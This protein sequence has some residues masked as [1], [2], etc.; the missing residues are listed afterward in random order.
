MES[1]VHWPISAFFFGFLATAFMDS[2]ALIQ[3]RIWPNPSFNYCLL[4]RW[5]LHIKTGNLILLPIYHSKQQPFECYIGW[6]SHY[7]IG[8]V[9]AGLYIVVAT[10]FSL[11]I[12]FI[13]VV[14]FGLLTVAAPFLIMQ[15]GLG[16]G[17][18]ASKTPNPWL[19]RLRSCIAHLSYGIG[20]F[21]S[22]QAFG[23][24]MK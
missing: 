6:F 8:I 1:E 16:L 14:G 24:V 4:G 18:F 2:W 17:F 12:S 21:L 20:L 22:F 10:F 9:F 19:V 23:K 13:T 11:E 15:P 7:V 3:K 5:L